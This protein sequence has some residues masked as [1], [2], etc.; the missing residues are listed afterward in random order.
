MNNIIIRRK[1]PVSLRDFIN[2][3]YANSKC[4]FLIE[5]DGDVLILQHLVFFLSND[6]ISFE[7]FNEKIEKTTFVC[8]VNDV[9]VYSLPLKLYS[10]KYGKKINENEIVIN[11]YSSVL[12][13]LLLYKLSNQPIICRIVDNDGLINIVNNYLL[14]F[15]FTKI[16]ETIKKR[17]LILN[18][19]IK[20]PFEYV[21][22]ESYSFLQSSAKKN[23][24]VDVKSR[25]LVKGVVFYADI[26]Y[27]IEIKLYING[28]IYIDYDVTDINNLCYLLT[29]KI[30]FL[31]LASISTNQNGIT[32]S[33]EYADFSN[34]QTCE[35]ELKFLKP[36][37]YFSIYSI[38][39]GL[40]SYESERISIELDAKNVSSNLS[41][42]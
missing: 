39:Q 26:F 5:N 36:Q 20:V 27:L 6:E 14:V 37:P 15:K 30:I 29:N 17:D 8:E 19:I 41:I 31:S 2:E 3:E 38:Q 10:E 32:S 25:G 1:C 13:E 11:L 9:E 4:E 23:I 18:N 12:R 21:T 22:Q 24:R 34:I 28:N 40:M 35:L 7:E 33:I 16:N 42:V